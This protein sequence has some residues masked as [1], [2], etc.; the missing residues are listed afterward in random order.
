MS[1]QSPGRIRV[2][3]EGLEQAHGG[4]DYAINNSVTGQTVDVL[5]LAGNGNGTRIIVIDGFDPA[6]TT[7]NN[8]CAIFGTVTLY[9]R[10]HNTPPADNPDVP[11]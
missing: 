1:T 11:T 2:F 6:D 8:A 4:M 3:Q 5:I 10:P 7:P 9:G